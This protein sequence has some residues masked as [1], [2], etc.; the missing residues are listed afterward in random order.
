MLSE[1][2]NLWGNYSLTIGLI[3]IAHEVFLMIVFSDVEIFHRL[4]LRN[5][6]AVPD[7]LGIQLADEILGNLFLL[8][9]VIVDAGTVLRANVRALAVESGGVMNREE[10]IQNVTD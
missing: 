7:T 8:G 4:Y 9:C 3:L 2:S 5:N 6:G 10:D 1:F